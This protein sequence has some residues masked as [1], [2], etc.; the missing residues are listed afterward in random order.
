MLASLTIERGAA[1]VWGNVDGLEL[2]TDFILVEGEFHMGSEYCPLKK[3]AFI[4]LTGRF[5]SLN[6][7]SDEDNPEIRKVILVREGATLEIHGQKKT[8]WTKLAQTTK[9]V[10]NYPCAFV[11]DHSDHEANPF[12]QE[13]SKGL[14]VIVWNEDGTVFDFLYLE[15]FFPIR[16]FIESIPDGKV[17]GMYAFGDGLCCRI[18]SNGMTSLDD[19]VINVLGGSLITKVDKGDSWSLVTRK[20][21]KSTTREHY[22]YKGRYTKDDEELY[23]QLPIWETR[24]DFQV[25]TS[26]K[27]TFQYFRVL[28]ADAAYPKLELADSVIGWSPG[29]KI[30]VASTDFDWEQAEVREI[31]DCNGECTNSQ[32]R[33][34]SPFQYTHYGNFTYN[35]DERAE[36]GI[37]SRNILIEGVVESECYATERA[38]FKRCKRFGGDTFGGH[39]R[40][41]R[42]HA[43]AH[44]EGVELYH[45]GQQG[46]MGSYPLHF[47]MCDEAPR[48]WFRD[49]SIHHSFQRC[50]TIHGTD[51]VEISGNVCYLH[52]GH[53]FFLEDS[54]EQ[55]NVIKGNL[56]IGT[57][58]GATL[59]SD[60]S[61]DW[62]DEDYAS[63]RGF[64]VNCDEP[65]TFWLTHPNNDVTDNAAAGGV[66]HGYMYVMADMP[67]G[68]SFERQKI[69]GKVKNDS[70]R[71]TP[72]KNFY[73]NV[74]HSYQRSG[75]FIDSHI[76]TGKLKAEEGV[77]ENGILQEENYFE[78]R[79][80]PGDSNG[81][82]VWSS[83]LERLTTYKN[84]QNNMWIK[85][86]NLRIAYSS[87]ADASS[88]S[89]SGGT[90]GLWTG[91]S[92][93]H[94]VFIGR[95]DNLGEATLYKEELPSGQVLSHQFPGSVGKSPWQTVTGMG[96]YQGP[97]FV[98]H[99][100][101]DRFTTEYW[102]DSWTGA[103]GTRPVSHAGAISFKK[104][105]TY[106]T[107]T[108]QYTTDLSF[109]F[110]DNRKDGHWLY[111]GQPSEYDWED[112]DGTKN[113]C[114]LD[115]DGSLT[116]TPKTWIVRNRPFFTGPECTYREDWDMSMCP[117]RYIKFELLG[118]GGNLDLNTKDQWALIGHR[119]DAPEDPF[120]QQ[121]QQ[122]REYLAQT[123]RSYLID[124]NTTMPG[125][126]FPSDIKI[127]G[128]GVERQDVIR[129]GVC[130]PL[131]LTDFEIRSDYPELINRNN[132]TRASSLEELDADT[133]NNAVFHDT[134]NG[135]MFFKIYSLHDRTNASQLCPAGLCYNI[136][137]ILNNGDLN[138]MRTC[139][140]AKFPAFT[141]TPKPAPTK[142]KLKTN[143]P[144]I[145]SPEGKGAVR[146]N[147]VPKIV[148][149]EYSV[150]CIES[151]P[152]TNRLEP[153]YEGCYVA[154]VQPFELEQ[155][156][157]R[158]M[159]ID[160]CTSRCYQR[161]YKYAALTQ[162]SV[163]LC[164]QTIDASEEGTDIRSRKC[165]QSC[166]GN[167]RQ[168]C[169]H[170]NRLSIWSTGLSEEHA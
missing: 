145:G 114:N 40:V 98:K 94:S 68:L 134:E 6:V 148:H 5:D 170:G 159:T 74:A 44:V 151:K 78:P 76:S 29:D 17:I 58:H 106:P 66:G 54:V 167:R 169:G 111:F 33:V 158:T 133:E 89:F 30:V 24:R 53:G 138:N 140:G 2:R 85:G 8:P 31:V 45:M 59:M 143:C 100:Y 86:G 119:D 88:Q 36:V 43:S 101:F 38:A 7:V 52:F 79:D 153:T 21:M 162:S 47:H 123:Y 26:A 136:R 39:I 135:I 13:R 81:E 23:L 61:K 87:L 127:Q 107:Y 137:I 102:N 3:T 146:W 126:A 60:S 32:I 70:A 150:P 99:T 83:R 163:C 72:I 50:I 132:Y 129:V 131:D 75:V 12:A 117:Y 105:S 90:T 11:Y 110:C 34:S 112:T 35:V 92:V 25:A 152:D 164:G 95:S 104:D 71:H 147:E 22:M 116:G 80:P 42:G 41:L 49:N 144:A 155:R 108:S 130:M 27:T 57:R 55:E 62:C 20:G 14:H 1:L 77:P 139:F 16:E 65:S 10:S 63:K 73:N 67:L 142:V 149:D 46:F 4:K 156:F 82:R 9:P 165:T 84:M 48:S 64:S 166:S 154:E 91:V 69:L 96:I 93:E 125:A 97:M 109:G 118:K 18:K 37:L 15:D 120:Y 115:L 168:K 128:N 124:F 122:R 51:K 160:W 157:Q 103:L 56:G 161:K 113:A 19:V 141:R 28:S 121:G